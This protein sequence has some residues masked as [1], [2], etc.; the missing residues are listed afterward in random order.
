MFAPA[1]LARMDD[2]GGC[3]NFAHTWLVNNMYVSIL[4]LLVSALYL[5]FISD[6]SESGI[7]TYQHRKGC[8]PEI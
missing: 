2:L 3:N 4:A 5:P 8:N 7:L 1:N 6:I